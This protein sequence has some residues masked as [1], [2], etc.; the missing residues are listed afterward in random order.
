M[1]GHVLR[2]GFLMLPLL[3]V[4]L[5]FTAAV[6][7][8]SDLPAE[9]VYHW[10]SV[11]IGGGGYVT[12]IVTSHEG[13]GVMY[14][15][16]DVGGAYRW[17]PRDETW[18]PLNDWVSEDQTGLLGI[19]S[20]TIDPSSPNR[21]YMMAGIDYFNNGN[22]AF[23][24][25]DNFGDTF[26]VINVTQ[27]FKAHG[28]GM[29][30]QNGERLAVD[31]NNGDI[32]YAGTRRDGLFVTTD[33]GDSWEHVS[34]LEVSQTPND[35]GI[36][37]VVIDGRTEE[38]GRSQRIIA[39]VSVAELEA[40]GT[41]YHGN[42]LY[43]SEDAG[44]S[45]E[46]VEGR[47]TRFMPQRAALSGDGDLVIT[48]GDGAGPHGHWNVPEPV[49]S[50]GIWSWNI[51]DRSWSD[52]TPAGLSRAFGGIS[53][54]P[55]NPDRMVA[56]TI[57]TWMDQGDGTW[58]D[59]VFY[60][61]DRGAGWTSVDLQKDDQGISWIQG[62]SIHWA[63]SIE[64]DPGNTDRV[65]VTS[66][67][68]IFM[69]GNIDPAAPGEHPW[70]FT[71]R[72]IE[73]TVP[74]DITNIYNGPLISVIGDY[75]GFVHHDVTEYSPIHEPQIGTSTGVDHA[76]KRGNMVVRVGGT[77]NGSNFPIYYSTDLGRSWSPFASLPDG[78]TYYQG[79]VAVAADGETVL[80]RPSNSNR[81]FRT[82]DRGRTW[83]QADGFASTRTIPVSDPANGSIFY[84]YNPSN[85]NV[86]ISRDA[87]SSF[88][89]KSSLPS[90]GSA[91]IR[92]APQREGDVWIALEANGLVRSAG[93][94]AEFEPVAGVD[95]AA[96]VGFGRAAPDHDYP[97]VYIWGTV[98]GITGLF[99]SVD[100]G[101]SW[102]RI[103][104][105]AHQYGGP[106]NG[107]FV[108]G[109][110]NIF[111]RV[112]MSTAGRGIVYGALENEVVSAD[113]PEAVASAVR[114]RQNYPNPFNPSTLISY[115]LPAETH[116]TIRVFDVL[117]RQVRVLVDQRQDAGLHHSVFDATGLSSGVYI[118]VLQAGPARKFR[119]MM[120]IK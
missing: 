7:V 3:F 65:L 77:S 1:F 82:T 76:E 113:Q 117:G 11:A 108:I 84:A 22:T 87:G 111:G 95:R 21:V 74:L 112:Y 40:G 81:I 4:T 110:P 12:A 98:G 25:S 19:E 47:P 73:E 18:I 42:N 75:D 104:D 71:V 114:L 68:G 116:V 89:V 36:S 92:T 102:V 70:K 57:N 60:S 90:G 32:L 51:D 99:R 50:G 106:G 96:A 56:S 39:G 48:Y 91:L 5:P 62:H 72:G 35:N 78:Q 33:R 103:N 64:F 59:R 45:W 46:L 93:P 14:A 30:R 44:E 38:N 20:L 2:V 10:N 8:A 29:G 97:S 120:Y 67:N 28:N 94:D 69:T 34:A 118:C 27:Q 100:E 88:S 9:E 49:E 79:R 23:L 16:T 101:S 15:R 63:G 41:R 6:S 17:N 31:P 43:I 13:D 83:T 61:E 66:G 24:R 55:A 26:D 85:G 37:F 109:D 86:M 58:G 119:S 105:D 53:M 107:N 52:I 54:D 80:W 115:E